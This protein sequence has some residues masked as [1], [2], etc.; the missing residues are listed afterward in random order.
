MATEKLNIKY[1]TQK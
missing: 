1:T